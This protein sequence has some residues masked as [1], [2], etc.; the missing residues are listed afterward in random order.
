LQEFYKEVK[1]VDRDNEVVRI[2]RAFKLNPFEQLGVNFDATPDEIRRAYRKL[3]LLVHPGA[4]HIEKLVELQFVLFTVF[5]GDVC[6]ALLYNEL[7]VNN[8]YS[9]TCR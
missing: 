3:S 2:L 8:R 9:C 4:N 1:S 5:C 6:N 7:R